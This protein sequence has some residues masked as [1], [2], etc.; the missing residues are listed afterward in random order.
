MS[1]DVSGCW[2][3][4]RVHVAIVFFVPPNLIPDFPLSVP[5]KS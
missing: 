4:K 3:Q 5:F 2:D 1:L